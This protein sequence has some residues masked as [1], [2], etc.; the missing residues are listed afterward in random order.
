MVEP[1]EPLVRILRIE[2]I[3]NVRSKNFLLL[4]LVGLLLL[5]G[6]GYINQKNNLTHMEIEYIKQKAIILSLSTYMGTEDVLIKNSTDS[7]RP[8]LLNTMNINKGKQVEI[9]EIKINSFNINTDK[10]IN[11]YVSIEENPRKSILFHQM[12]FKKIDGMWELSDFS[13][14]A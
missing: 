5:L 2:V 13:N 4:V 9:T 7:S 8:Y 14:D 3:A 11:V 12:T 10:T 1:L 6:Y